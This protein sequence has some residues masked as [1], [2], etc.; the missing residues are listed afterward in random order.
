VDSDL[1]QLRDDL[2]R[3]E[4][5]AAILLACI[6]RELAE[7][8]HAIGSAGALAPP[9]NTTAP[10]NSVTHAAAVQGARYPLSA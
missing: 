4:I 8:T 6:E 1:E 5:E 9:S 2:V 10:T 3:W 7:P